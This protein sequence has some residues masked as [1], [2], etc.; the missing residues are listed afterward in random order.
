[1]IKRILL[2]VQFLTRLPVIV[3][4]EADEADIAGSAVF[5][6]LTGLIIAGILA[7]AY[8]LL[9]SVLPAFVVSVLVL[10]I[11]I[12]LTGSLHL[13]GFA[14][15]VDGFYGGKNKEEILKIMDD[16]R[17][18]AIGAV[19]LFTVITLFIAL[20]TYLSKELVPALLSAIVL[21]RTGA[22]LLM[23][24]SKPAK[25]TGLANMFC[26]KITF[27]HALL[28]YLIAACICAALGWKAIAGLFIVTILSVIAAKYF[29]RKLGGITGDTIGF[30]IVLFEAVVLIYWLIRIS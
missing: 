12:L 18:G 20:F 16:S 28:A 14:D 1:M 7:G 19:W 29:Q 15:T 6:P 8:F 27:L 9:F 21:G 10:F 3:P 2:S 25:K 26:G 11:Y 17:I 13:D 22:V 23:Y 5:F 30:S 24:F 4:G